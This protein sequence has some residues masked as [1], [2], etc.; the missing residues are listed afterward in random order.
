[1]TAPVSGY[2]LTHDVIGEL[3]LVDID[4]SE[5]AFGFLL[6]TDGKFTD[7]NGKVWWGS[8]VLKASR[9]QHALNGVAPGGSITVSYFQ[10]PSQSSL[11]GQLKALG[12]DYVAGREIRFY[13]Q[14]LLSI[15]ELY[16]PTLPP[17]LEM[18]RISRRLIFRET[19]ARNREIELFFE[20]WAE[21]RRMA[22]RRPLDQRGHEALLGEDNPSLSF[23]PPADLPDEEI[24]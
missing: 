7:V 4:T 22:K 6:G 24:W 3:L 17:Q 18:T 16:T 5:G 12:P 13:S 14:P 21:V 20:S 23:K 15:A 8:T 10:D 11:A 2:D 9:Q 19:G 1:M